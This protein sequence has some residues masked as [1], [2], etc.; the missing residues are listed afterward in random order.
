MA[1]SN[2]NPLRVPPGSVIVLVGP[3][4]SGKSTYIRNV[5]VAAGLNDNA[6]V[7]ADLERA[8]LGNFRHRQDIS[9]RAHARVRDLLD[10]RLDLGM[11]TVV[12]NTSTTHKERKQLLDIA[13]R[14]DAP[15]FAVRFDVELDQTRQFNRVGPAD[16]RVPDKVLVRY[17]AR[18]DSGCQHKQ[19]TEFDHVIDH[20]DDVNW[21]V[22]PDN[23]YDVDASHLAGP[24]DI[25]GDVH[26][27][28]AA[29]AALLEALGY[30][31]D[32]GDH[33]NGR[34]LVSVGDLTDK[35]PNSADVVARALRLQRNGNLLMVD[36][37]HGAAF[38]RKIRKLL[39]NGQSAQQIADELTTRADNDPKQTTTRMVADSVSQFAARS[40]GDTLLNAAF[41]MHAGA[42]M[43]LLL[44]RGDLLVVH[45]GMRTDLIGA[46]HGK[47]LNVFRY[48]T[49]T[50]KKDNGLPSGRDSWI[51]EYTGHPTVVYGHIAYDDGPRRTGNCIGVDT[52]AADGHQLTS[53]AWPEGGTTSVDVTTLEVTD[54][55]NDVAA[56]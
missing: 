30:D 15:T 29:F 38:V 16:E 9:G 46:T 43:H 42:P 49:P 51:H 24:F 2:T 54:D 1:A 45:G 33:I 55:H 26:G 12:D 5:L 47:A 40:D 22:L 52:G 41:R 10:E 7:S 20:T 3:P 56:A 18:F 44:D 6:V 8:R 48:G 19:L 39:A 31:P 27:H 21:Q 34:M 37:N 28:D 50:G 13:D 25:I 14:Y 35:G 36:S 23:P 11:T 4:R 17:R 53:Y 32:T